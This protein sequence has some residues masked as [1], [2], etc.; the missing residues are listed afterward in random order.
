MIKSIK[1]LLMMVL[2]SPYLFSFFLGT[3]K[4]HTQQRQ[5]QDPNN[6]RHKF[7]CAFKICICTWRKDKLK[8]FFALLRNEI[9]LENPMIM[10]HEHD[11][12]VIKGKIFFLSAANANKNLSMMMSKTILRESSRVGVLYEGRR[13]KFHGSRDFGYDTPTYNHVFAFNAI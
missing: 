13:S 2:S 11:E 8:L 7:L 10:T 6:R 1:L 12:E 5:S 9:S 4:V 3:S